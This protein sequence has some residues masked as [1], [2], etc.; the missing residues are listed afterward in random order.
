VIVI[1]MIVTIYT[2]SRHCPWSAELKEMLR[3][4]N[5]E[6][7]EYFPYTELL[8]EMVER[9]NYPSFPHVWCDEVGLPSLGRPWRISPLE[10]PGVISR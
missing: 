9:Y 6:Y 1:I 3:Y 7:E 8:A 2:S 5:S 4:Y 10:R